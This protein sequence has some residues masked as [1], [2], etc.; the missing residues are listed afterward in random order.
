MAILD[1]FKKIPLSAGLKKRLVDFEQKVLALEKENSSLKAENAELKMKLSQ[2][3]DQRR[4]HEKQITEIQSSTSSGY[5][6]DHCGS[7]QLTQIGNRPDPAFG[8]LGIK[9]GIEQSVFVCNECGRE[10][11]FTQEQ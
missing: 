9:L 1:W 4:A 6:C 8:R 2:A 3:E 5:V 10:S 11:A 7:P